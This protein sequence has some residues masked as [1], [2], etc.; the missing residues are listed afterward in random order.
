MTQFNEKKLDPIELEIEANMFMAWMREGH[1]IWYENFALERGY[2][3]KLFEKFAEKST[4]FKEVLRYAVEWQRIK[5]I[6]NGLLGHY[7]QGVVKTVLSHFYSIKDGTS[8]DQGLTVE[9]VSYKEV[10]NDEGNTSE[11]RSQTLPV[12]LLEMD[13]QRREESCSSMAP[14]IREGSDMLELDDKISLPASW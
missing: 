3:P 12:G 2:S 7:N 9:I 11:L 13:G 14:P 6:E 4:R 1:G 10:E 5:L 8:E